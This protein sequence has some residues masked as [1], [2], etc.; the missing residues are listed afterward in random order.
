MTMSKSWHLAIPSV[1]WR[2]DDNHTPVQCQT[3]EEY[4]ASVEKDH[5][6][7]DTQIADGIRV[8]TV[9]LHSPS[10]HHLEQP[11]FFETMAFGGPLDHFVCRYRT[12]D[13]ALAGHER[14][15]DEIGKLLLL[16]PEELAAV[17]S[18]RK[19]ERFRFI[20]EEALA[21]GIP[22]ELADHIARALNEDPASDD[23]GDR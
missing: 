19:S 7:S 2:L 3:V 16:S 12:Y 11:E 23:A 22:E 15:C 6:V 9:F 1:F 8:S 4:F 17:M 18:Q 20:R 13:E 21:M 10:A 14:V 5:R